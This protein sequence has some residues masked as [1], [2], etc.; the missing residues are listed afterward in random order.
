MAANVYHFESLKFGEQDFIMLL[1]T[2]VQG[3]KYHPS[4]YSQWY[5][6]S[7][8]LPSMFELQS[9]LLITYVDTL[10]YPT[11]NPPKPNG[12]LLTAYSEPTVPPPTVK[13]RHFGIYIF[14]TEI[15]VDLD[16]L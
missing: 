1:V 15:T 3:S 4:N 6:A 14:G 16:C 2:V 10:T 5:H 9:Y 13:L 7:S 11:T 8:K 12:S